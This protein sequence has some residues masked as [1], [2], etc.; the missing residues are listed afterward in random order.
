MMAS[1]LACRDACDDGGFE[2]VDLGEDQWK[3]VFGGRED[4]E[5][6]GA[7]GEGE[8]DGE[9]EGGDAQL[10][11]N[12]V[13][14]WSGES[15]AQSTPKVETLPVNE[16]FDFDQSFAVSNT[17]AAITGPFQSGHNANSRG[18]I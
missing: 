9:G 5:H 14:R 6:E 13:L 1:T 4:H 15:S 18:K 3:N 11:L 16:F 17:S 2:E 7:G 12:G 10:R 8:G